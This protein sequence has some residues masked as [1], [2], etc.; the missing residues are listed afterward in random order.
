MGKIS[1]EGTILR[2]ALFYRNYPRTD[3]HILDANSFHADDVRHTFVLF[4]SFFFEI[5]NKNP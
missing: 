4:Y 3:F 5:Q 1:D 2:I